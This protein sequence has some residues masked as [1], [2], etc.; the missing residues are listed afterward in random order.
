MMFELLV[1]ASISGAV[2]AGIVWALCRL[3]PRLSPATRAVLWWCVAAKF[4]I[5]LVWVT[6]VPVPVLPATAR[7]ASTPSRDVIPA[8]SAAA[9]Y[10][11]DSSPRPA[12]APHDDDL[13]ARSAAAPYRDATVI[14]W[15]AGALVALGLA[16]RRWRRMR[17]IVR[18]SAPATWQ[19]QAMAEE[20]SARLGLSA[21]P[22]VRVSN[23]VA[24][25]L[26]AG[27][28]PPIVVLPADR[29]SGL[30]VEQQRMAVC[31]ELAHVQRHDL[32]LGCV[33]ALIERLFF[34]HPLAILAA[35]E[36]ALWREAACDEMVLEALE[37]APRDYGRLLLDLGVTRP[38]VGL[39]VAGAPWSFRNLQR[40]LVM[41]GRPSIQSTTSRYLAA[42]AVATALAALLPLQLVGRT[43]PASGE[44][45]VSESAEPTVVARAA[46]PATAP[47]IAQPVRQ[48]R[49]SDSKA[50]AD[51]SR[52]DD[53]NFTVLL[54]DNNI[55]HG[56]S[57]DHGRAL[58]FRRGN[59]PMVWFRHDGKEYVI[60]DRNVI[61]QV[62]TIWKPIGELGAE[63]G[64]L[65][66]QQGALGAKQGEYGAQQ[67]ALGAKQGT[68]GSRMGQLGAKQAE[69]AVRD[70]R[71]LTDAER[72]DLEREH[73]ELEIEMEKVSK[74][75]E[76]LG[77][78]MAALGPPMEELGKQMEPL[79]KEMEVLGQKMEEASRQAESQMRSLLERAVKDGTA[80]T[81][82]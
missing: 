36:Y 55:M 80:E 74:D 23:L 22:D 46:H 13:P 75:M 19:A 25:P 28:R 49:S 48:A 21:A 76:K 57:R 18:K 65:G 40:R 29:F 11:D 26:V 79:G 54:D 8:R 42:A 9:A 38:G 45:A 53:L 50:K 2:V 58:S 56:S 71:E 20:L 51:T 52:K 24:T 6:P 12:S 66:A 77:E 10:R 81:V 41:L 34:F 33:P 14:A 63:Q 64:K 39:A 32:V 82:K 43:T 30:S 15:G 72:R 73:Q 4:L 69:L 67:G 17:I 27:L 61:A 44:P 5:A 31:H 35:R 70:T 78:E 7:S 62:E 16:A 59:E 3:V 68:L 47:S 37:A 1:R 60:R